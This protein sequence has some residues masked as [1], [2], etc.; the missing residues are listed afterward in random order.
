M[1]RQKPQ[2]ACKS[3]RCFTTQLDSNSNFKFP[4]ST[5]MITLK[6]KPV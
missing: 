1:G 4:L 6:V 2:K 3:F 5:R